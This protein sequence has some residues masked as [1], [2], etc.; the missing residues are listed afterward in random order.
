MRFPGFVWTLCNQA[1]DVLEAVLKPHISHDWDKALSAAEQALVDAE[2]E[3]E[4]WSPGVNPYGSAVIIGSPEPPHLSWG[5]DGATSQCLRCG[6]AGD[7]TCLRD[8]P[9]AG[10]AT[11]PP[12]SQVAGDPEE[13]EPDPPGAPSSGTSF[14]QWAVPAVHTI[15]DDHQ[16]RHGRCDCGYTFDGGI[17]WFDWCVHVSPLVSAHL[18]TALLHEFPRK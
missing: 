7:H 11:C 8:S 9:A 10:A 1:A 5:V 12:A 4:L 18:E 15:L 16:Y 13:V 3:N 17:D 2:A 14:V 6:N